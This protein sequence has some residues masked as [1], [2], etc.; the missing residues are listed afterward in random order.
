MR[1]F[2]PRTSRATEQ[3]TGKAQNSEIMEDLFYPRDPQHRF[4]SMVQGDAGC[5]VEELARALKDST[6]ITP[7]RFTWICPHEFCQTLLRAQ[8]P[9]QQQQQAPPRPFIIVDTRTADEAAGGCVVGA[10]RANTRL[11]QDAVQQLVGHYRAGRRIFF[12]C[13]RSQARAPLAAQNLLQAIDLQGGR[14]AGESGGGDRTDPNVC[15]VEG[16]LVALVQGLIRA[17]PAATQRMLVSLHDVDQDLP[18]A[19][20]QGL[21]ADKWAVTQTPDGPVVA[22]VTELP[23]WQLN[24]EVREAEEL[25]EAE[26]SEELAYLVDQRMSLSPPAAGQFMSYIS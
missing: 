23:N 4:G 8:L 24:P 5:R 2:L 11:S 17:V 15:V 1:G 12:Y 20:I 26:M 10:I 14:S 22:H 6:K 18:T 7:S 3:E 16:G 19:I 9:A 25:M 21:E 13:L